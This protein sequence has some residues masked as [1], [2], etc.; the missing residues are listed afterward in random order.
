MELK[1]NYKNTKEDKKIAQAVVA[2]IVLLMIQFA[3]LYGFNIVG[4]RLEDIIQIITKLIVV[5]IFIR[6][7]GTVFKREGRT[8][9]FTY[10]TISMII[11]THYLF[12]EYNRPYI[13]QVIFKLFF[14]S[15]PS[16]I[17]AKSIKSE[18][19]LVLAI[20][21]SSDI[22]FYI[23]LIIGVLVM[24]GIINIGEYSMTYSYYMVFPVTY[25]INIFINEKKS[26]YLYMSLIGCTLILAIGSRGAL[27]CIGAYILIESRKYFE[28]INFKNI[29]IFLFIA[30][31]LIYIT[32]KFDDILIF[33]QA[34]LE[35][36][37]IDSRSI[38]ILLEGGIHTSGRDDLYNT[39]IKRVLK[40]PLIGIGLCGDR[41]YI[42]NY[43]H[44]IFI[45]IIANFGIIIGG[46]V[47]LMLI[48]I[49]IKSIFNNKSKTLSFW[50]A[51]SIIP[52]LMSNS[53]I[54]DIK[55]WIFLGVF[56]NKYINNR[57]IPYIEN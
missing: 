46:I 54:I 39:I 34:N 45:E 43:V 19:S 53:Y 48:V 44:N 12:F 18:D 41:V 1:D 11:L 35:K 9:V 49:I 6:C 2:P 27:V 29:I 55:F 51:I 47:S 7:I 24:G 42:G 17:Y 32:F 14:M 4:T 13:N 56:F 10:L 26:K 38:R 36:F 52:L 30:I 20:K 40:N 25:Y 28:E 23:G 50:M 22:I 33:I 5:I 15:I 8:F 21:R 57:K 31:L 37:G 3:I 16:F